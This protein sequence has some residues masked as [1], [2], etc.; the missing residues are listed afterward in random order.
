[1]A[2]R[3]GRTKVAVIDSGVVIAGGKTSSQTQTTVD[4]L[5]S[6]REVEPDLDNSNIQ[7]AEPGKSSLE[8]RQ[9]GRD[10]LWTDDLAHRV[11]DGKS[12]VNT[13]DDEE[14]VWWHASEPHGTQMARLIC[15][16]DPYCDL[17]VVK[18]AETRRSG[19]SAN[20]VAEVRTYS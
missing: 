9:K 18:V 14:Q 20:V 3:E 6:M 4:G 8:V 2:K 12:F 19:I 16:I 7:M 11:V 5:G 13:G 17:Y 10:R 15:S 1:M